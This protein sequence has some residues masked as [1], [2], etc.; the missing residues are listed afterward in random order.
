MQFDCYMPVGAAKLDGDLHLAF[1]PEEVF[2]V[3]KGLNYGKAS[4]DIVHGEV[5]KPLVFDLCSL[6]V[7][8]FNQVAASGQIPMCWRGASICAIPK[9]REPRACR[10]I[11]LLVHSQRVFSRVLLAQVLGRLKDVLT[12]P[13]NQLALSRIGGCEKAQVLLGNFDAWARRERL[14]CSHLHIDLRAAF[15]VIM[16]Q[17]LTGP[18]VDVPS[19]DDL[20]NSEDMSLAQL[21]NL[22][23]FFERKVLPLLELQGIPRQFRDILRAMES[24]LWTRLPQI[25]GVGLAAFAGVPVG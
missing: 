24:G 8:L 16:R 12:I 3:L 19:G 6:L 20:D 11:S 17:A 21:C 15:D 22:A 14:S 23:S 4:A 7:N 10:P 5:L 1:S 25:P 18:H 2:E 9:P 13:S